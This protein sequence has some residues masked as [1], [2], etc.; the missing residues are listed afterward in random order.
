MDSNGR[1]YSEHFAGFIASHQE[2][3]VPLTQLHHLHSRYLQL[4][5]S[6]LEETR[7]LENRYLVEYGRVFAERQAIIDPGRTKVPHG[8]PEFWLVAMKNNSTIADAIQP[9]DEEVLKFLKDVRVETL[10]KVQGF[11]LVFEFDENNFFTNKT[12]TKTFKYGY[13]NDYTGDLKQERATGCEIDWNRGKELTAPI[14]SELDGGG[15]TESF[16]TFFNTSTNEKTNKRKE[17]G[18]SDDEDESDWAL[19]SDFELGEEFNDTLVPHALYWYTGEARWYESDDDDVEDDEEG[20]DVDGEDGEDE[21]DEEDEGDESE[22]EMPVS[23]QATS[24][25]GPSAQGSTVGQ[26]PVSPSAIEYQNIEKEKALRR[27]LAEK[28][29][30]L[31]KEHADTLTSVY[32]LARVLRDL[33]KCKEGEKMSR[34]ALEGREKALGKVHYQTLISVN[35]LALVLE[36]QGKFKE[37][38]E[39]SQRYLEGME[40]LEGKEHYRTL[41]A[42]SNL[43]LMLWHQGKSEAAEELHRR[44]LEGREKALGK[45]HVDTLTSVSH[46]ALAL[47]DQGR[48]EEAEQMGLRAVK[49]REKTLGREHPDTQE[50]VN[51]LEWLQ[52]RQGKLR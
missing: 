3:Q 33:G 4:N 34:R 49:G 35:A 27:E 17:S 52:R 2:I 26:A 50:S 36:R 9:R 51:N 20:G 40:K 15:E 21:E 28:E 18:E 39:M 48:Y 32:D 46:M 37:A 12:L 13:E 5:K 1:E 22:E 29:K 23:R 44:A 42:V 14:E 19:D 43:A 30:A 45:E 16:F 25:P 47:R 31:G 6:F 41:M 8:I 10:G 11:R 24:V 7:E 38:E